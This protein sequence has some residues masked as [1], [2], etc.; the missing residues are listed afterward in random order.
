VRLLWLGPAWLAISNRPRHFQQ[1]GAETLPFLQLNVFLGEIDCS[2]VEVL[3]QFET[4]KREQGNGKRIGPPVEA[5]LV[6]EDLLGYVGGND[7][8]AN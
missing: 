6:P 8:R 5:I 4:F 7:Y 2:D 3:A 1:R